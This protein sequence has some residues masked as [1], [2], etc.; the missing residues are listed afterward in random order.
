M[1]RGA[2]RRVLIG[3]LA[4]EG[5]KYVIRARGDRHVIN[6]A[7]REVSIWKIV[8]RMKYKEKYTVEVD[9]EGYTEKIELE[10]AERQK[11]KI[12]DIPVRIIAI[13]GFGKKPMILLTNLD[14]PMHEMLEIYLTR[15]KCE[16][17][18]RFLKHEYH[19]EDVRVRSYT[20]L[21]NTVA[22]IHAVYYFLSVHL[23]RGMRLKILLN[24]ILEKAKR[25]FEIPNFKHYA[26]ADGIFRLLFNVKWDPVEIKEEEEIKRQLLFG[27]T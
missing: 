18:F 2:D 10:L 26:V 20:G 15:W 9:R 13:R 16:E 8:W 4:K 11:V 1:D 23:G 24:K 19:L 27:F 14:K 12:G 21:R 7:G 22:L 25:F 3:E 5:L 6:R 17:S